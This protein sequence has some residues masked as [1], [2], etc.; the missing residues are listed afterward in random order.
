ML[1]HVHTHVRALRRAH[2]RMHVRAMWRSHLRAQTRAHMH[3]MI[4][5][6]S[7]DRTFCMERVYYHV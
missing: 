5:H 2:W 6:C 1:V 7:Y 4:Q 3:I